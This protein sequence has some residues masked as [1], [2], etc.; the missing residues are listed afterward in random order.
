MPYT[1]PITMDEFAIEA[2][3]TSADFAVLTEMGR[4]M[5]AI[6][7]QAESATDPMAMFT[8]MAEVM[9]DT[10]DAFDG[11]SGLLRVHGVSFED[12]Y[13][14]FALD[15]AGVEVFTG[16]LLG[17][18]ASLG[19]RAGMDGLMLAQA[20]LPPHLMPQEISAGIVLEGLPTEQIQSAFATFLESAAQV[21]PDMAMMAFG[22][23]LQQ[24]VMT[25]GA[26]LE[27]EEILFINEVTHFEMTG[28]VTP[29]PTAAFQMVAEARIEF[30][31]MEGLIAE[32]QQIPPAA[33][34]F[35]G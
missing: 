7:Q 2:S 25:E 11:L 21:G 29:D 19:V 17:P 12:D 30:V 4:S 35:R 33:R 24:A 26:T 3:A 10:T 22:M 13:E 6:S 28:T 27:I 20:P 15:N 31:N 32:L 14:G 18:A 9:R 23:G 16:G 5:N 8:A 34:P 1:G